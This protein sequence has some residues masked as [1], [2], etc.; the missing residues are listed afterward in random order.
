MT[1]AG[2]HGPQAPGPETLS[3]AVAVAVAVAGGHSARDIDRSMNAQMRWRMR[4][5]GEDERGAVRAWRMA[6][7]RALEAFA[8]FF[9]AAPSLFV[10]CLLCVWRCG[11]GVWPFALLF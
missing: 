9:T 4:G 1:R 7:T 8:R 6:H 11:G 5:E 3:G 10:F 2:N